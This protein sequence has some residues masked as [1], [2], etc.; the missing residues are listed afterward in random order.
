MTRFE[1]KVVVITGG[2][3]GIGRAIARRVHAEGGSVIVV[4]IN[5]TG[6]TKSSPNSGTGLR[7]TPSTCGT[8]LPSR[9]WPPRSLRPGVSTFS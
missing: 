5:M 7:V 3:S 4:D 1:D 8:A 6:S 2:A 9:P